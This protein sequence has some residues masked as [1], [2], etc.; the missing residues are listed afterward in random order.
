LRVLVTGGAGYI[1]STTAALLLQ[2]GYD[3]TV[4]DNLS[5]GHKS[6]VPGSA[7]FVQGDIGDSLSLGQILKDGFDGLV[8]FAAMIEA[9]ES[10]REPALYFTGNTCASIN[11]LNAAVEHGVRY[12]VF[13]STAAVYASK[14]TPLLE[15]DTIKP[16]NVYGQTKRQIEEVLEWYYQVY[17]I[18]SCILRYFNASGA[19]TALDQLRGEDHMPETHLIPAILQTAL[20][21]REQISIFGGD[22][23]TRDGTNIR[24][25]IHIEDLARAHLLALQALSN[26][27]IDQEVYNLGNGRG[28]SNKEVLETARQITREQIPAVITKRRP[29][30]AAKLVASS[31]KIRRELGWEP[32]IP[33]LEAIIESAWKWHKSF[34]NGYDD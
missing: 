9:G 8:H 26:G 4:V 22:Y 28:Y 12:I 16:A 33:E 17:G 15:T 25:Y 34:P 10:M 29:G 30:D 18:R 32:M 14:D 21:Q 27:T 20:G 6:A 3:V 5:R 24:D 7:R 2:A 1:G 31:D 23:P 13:S 11:L 19:S